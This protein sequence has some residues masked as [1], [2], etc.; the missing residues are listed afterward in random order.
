MIRNILVVVAVGMSAGTVWAEEPLTPQEISRAAKEGI[1]LVGNAYI[2][3]RQAENP[4]LILVDVRSESEFELGHIPGAVSI[5]R[6]VAE[7]RIAN[8]VRDADAEIIVYCATGVRSALIKKALDS[9]GYRNVSAHE[10]FDTWAEA[11]Q[12]VRNAYG[13]FSLISRAGKE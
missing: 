12:P 10:G 4:E 6:G 13:T 7:F 3:A 1:A 5:P 11:G 2:R 9:Q 8:D